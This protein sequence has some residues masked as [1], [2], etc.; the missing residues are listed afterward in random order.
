MKALQSLIAA[1][2][3][4]LTSTGFA[5]DL[6]GLDKNSGVAGLPG[7]GLP[8]ITGSGLP[9]SAEAAAALKLDV[10]RAEAAADPDKFLDEHS[11]AEAGLAF[12]LAA[13]SDETGAYG[14]LDSRYVVN[15]SVAQLAAVRIK[16]DL[17]AQ[18]LTVE[19]PEVNKAFK[20][21]SGVPPAHTTPGSGRCFAPDSMEVMHYSSLY[22]NAPMPNAIFFNG[23]IAIHATETEK[24]LGQPASHG[25]VRLSHVDAKTL[26]DIV[27][28]SG[29][30]NTSI[31][32]EGE[33][34]A[35]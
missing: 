3:L 24:L 18:R 9:G 16:V 34:P 5:F 31:C 20:I 33:T 19:G 35:K 32:V 26:F 13:N 29:K 28:A 23:N 25:C 10:L 30:T 6:P 22:N 7:A 8:L 21:S 27:K 12:G 11:P 4:T 14:I 2:L 15:N 17:D 1:F